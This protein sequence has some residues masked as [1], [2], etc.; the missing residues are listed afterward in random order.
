MIGI[1]SGTIDIVD[2]IRTTFDTRGWTDRNA[3]LIPQLDELAAPT[4][5]KLS[6]RNRYAPDFKRPPRP[7]IQSSSNSSC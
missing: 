5:F 3:D 7:S 2:P 1:G 6:T 4:G